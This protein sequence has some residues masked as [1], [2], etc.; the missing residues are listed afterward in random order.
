MIYYKYDEGLSAYKFYGHARQ[1][2]K[3]SN[4]WGHKEVSCAR[5][6]YLPLIPRLQRLYA[7]K[8]TVVHMK[9]QHEHCQELGVLWHPLDGLAWKDFDQEYPNFAAEPRNVRLGLYVLGIKQSFNI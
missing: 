2:L 4:Q 5:M 9:W 1:L 6:H 3:N 8:S 7:S